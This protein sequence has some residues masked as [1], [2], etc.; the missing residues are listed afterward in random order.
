MP[1]NAW[2]AIY[3]KVLGR[4]NDDI[5]LLNGPEPT[6]VPDLTAVSKSSSLFAS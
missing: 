5:L 6:F 3:F 2:E 4:E 1:K